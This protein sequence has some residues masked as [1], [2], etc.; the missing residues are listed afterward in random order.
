MNE[1]SWMQIKAI[2]Y[3]LLSGSFLICGI[4]CSVAAYLG[5]GEGPPVI[6]TFLVLGLSVALLASLA[7]ATAALVGCWSVFEYSNAHTNSP[8][9]VEGF[10]DPTGAGGNIS[11]DPS[12]LET[13]GSEGMLWDLHLGNGSPL[14][15]AGNPATVDPDGSPSDIG[16]HGGPDAE[17]WDL[18]Q[19]G[20]DQWWLPGGYDA[21]TSPGMDCDD[22]DAS[23]FPGPGC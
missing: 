17:S 21:A 20:H 2:V 15:D 13:T 11:V 1:R 19:D 3:A 8:N 10:G 9:D 6:R 12:Y 22:L 4:F 18:D 5:W 16:A 14:I 23:V 7:M